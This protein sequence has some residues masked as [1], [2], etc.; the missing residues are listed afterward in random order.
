MTRYG[1]A[2]IR[3]LETMRFTH[4]ADIEE[5][6]TQVILDYPTAVN[7]VLPQTAQPPIQPALIPKP[8]GPP[9][10]PKRKAVAKEINKGGRAQ[11]PEQAPVLNRT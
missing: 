1:D 2:T 9:R 11:A 8:P 7:A 10:A 4:K 5:R 3:L 6:E